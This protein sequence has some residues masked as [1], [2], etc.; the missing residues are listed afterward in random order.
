MCQTLKF[1]NNFFNK[2]LALSIF[3]FSLALSSG[4]SDSFPSSGVARC[5]RIMHACSTEPPFLSEIWCHVPYNGSPEWHFL[6]EIWC[7]VPY[8]W[9][10]FYLR[11]WNWDNRIWLW[12]AHRLRK[13]TSSCRQSSAKRP[14][15][16]SADSGRGSGRGDAKKKNTKKQKIDCNRL[17]KTNRR[18][19]VR[20][21][22]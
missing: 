14:L 9:L 4:S 5:F 10:L 8:G 11:R 1:F 6:Y 20:T 3:T 17:C 12:L 16:L 2:P 21:L 18:G 22:Q 19:L 7:H 15:K 13:W